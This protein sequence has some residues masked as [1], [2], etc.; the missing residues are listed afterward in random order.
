MS[1]MFG[2]FDDHLAILIMKFYDFA[3]II[4]SNILHVA[5]CS[6]AF[7]QTLLKKAW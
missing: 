5:Y 1:L 2:Q 4:L 3:Q 6:Q 7:V